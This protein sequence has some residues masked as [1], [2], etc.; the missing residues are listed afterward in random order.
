MLVEDSV[1]LRKLVLRNGPIPVVYP[2][3]VTVGRIA[4][5]LE[6]SIEARPADLDGDGVPL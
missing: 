4:W 1:E 3:L 6:A 5:R 2:L